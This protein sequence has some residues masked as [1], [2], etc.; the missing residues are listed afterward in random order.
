MWRKNWRKKGEKARKVTERKMSNKHSLEAG[1]LYIYKGGKGEKRDGKKDGQ[2][3]FI[4]SM[5][6]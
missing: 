2:Y 5:Q 1:K 3:A 6:V 4:R